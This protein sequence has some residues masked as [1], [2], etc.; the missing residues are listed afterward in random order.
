MK[1]ATGAALAIIVWGLCA[2]LAQAQ[3]VILAR[4]A[5]KGGEGADPDLSEAGAA[6]AQALAQTLAHAGVTHVLTTPYRRTIQT[7]APTATAGGIA[8]VAV[9]TDA[10]VDHVADVAS[11]VRRLP[12]DAVVLVVGHS[13]TVPE[14]ARALGDPA[15]EALNECDFDRLVVLTLDGAE[16]PQVVRARYGAPS[17]AC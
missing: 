11:R 17:P 10:G 15:P 12:A 4:H 2:P 7:A 13:N 8:S 9:P 14:I 5:E 3:T 1:R 6:R 16:A